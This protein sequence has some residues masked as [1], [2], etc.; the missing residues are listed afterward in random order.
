MSGARKA[1]ALSFKG[2]II[3][4]GILPQEHECDNP[5]ARHI[6]A[7]MHSSSSSSSNALEND[8]GQRDSTCACKPPQIVGTPGGKRHR[9]RSKSKKKKKLKKAKETL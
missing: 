2:V 1:V 3:K 8:Q 5:E 7:I 4:N 9:N 6:S